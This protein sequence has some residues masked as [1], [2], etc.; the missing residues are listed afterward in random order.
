MAKRTPKNIIAACSLLIL[1]AFVVAPV[2]ADPTGYVPGRFIVKL[3]AGTRFSVASQSLGGNARINPLYPAPMRTSL[4]SVTDW[5][6]YAIVETLDSAAT[7]S[8][9]R[10]LIGTTNVEYVEQD[11]Y[12]DFYE[13]PTDSLFPHQWWLVNNGQE[14]F[15]IDR[16]EGVNNDQLILKT[17]A[18]ETDASVRGFYENP[19]A[20]TTRVIV[21]VIDTGTD[22]F[23]PELAGR[24]W[25]NPDEIPANGIDDDHNGFVDDTIGYDISGD[26]PEF[27]NIQGDNDV[28]DYH[29]HGTHIAGIIAANADGK[30]VVGLA[31]WAE[32][33]TVKVRPNGFL[34]IGTAGVLYAVNNGA[35]V[36]NI[37]WGTP[38]QAVIL[39]DALRFARQNEVFVA[40]AAGNNGDNRRDP[41]AALDSVFAVAAGTSDGYLTNFSSWGPFVDVVAPGEDIL[42]LRASGTDMYGEGGEP[43]VHII[44]PD[45]LYYLS[46]G[47]SMASPI[48]AGSAALIWSFRPDLSRAELETLLRLGADDMTDPRGIGDTLVGP[49]TLSGYGYLNVYRSFQMAGSG[50]LALLEPLQQQRYTGA[51]PIKAAA[52]AG[53]SGQ[54]D[55]EYSVGFMSEDWQSLA[56]GA[57]VPLNS[58]LHVFDLPDLNGWVNLRLTDA[59]GRHSFSRFIYVNSSELTLARPAPDDTLRY[60]VS[61]SGSAFGLDYDSL[62]VSY[63]N[64]TGVLFRLFTSTREFFD[65]TITVWNASGVP[66]GRYTFYLAGYFQSNQTVDSASVF[67]ASAFAAGWPRTL[68]SKGPLSVVAADLDHDGFKEVIA[69]S[70]YG[71]FV[72]RHDGS[73]LTGFPAAPEKD[74]RCMPAIYNV[75]GDPED[76]IIATGADGLYVFNIDGTMVPGWPQKRDMGYS[77]AF[78]YPTPTVATLQEGGPSVIMLI[79]GY[80][81]ILAYRLNGESHFYSLGGHFSRFN[82]A[83]IPIY[84]YAANSVSVADLNGDGLKEVIAGYSGWY[85]KSGVAV[86]DGRTGRPAFG[87][88]APHVVDGQLLF[89]FILADL[90]GDQLPEIIATAQ[91]SVYGRTIFVKTRK[92]DGSGMQDSPGWPKRFP[93]LTGWI[94][95]YPMVADLDLDSIPEVLCTFYEFD[96]A[97]LYIY[98]ADGTPYVSNGGRPEGEAFNAPVT[99]GNPIVADLTGDQHPEI[100]IRSGYIL[101]ATGPERIYI[102]DHTGVL[103]PGYPITTPANPRLVISSTFSPM[104][105]D[106]DNDSL[107][108]LALHGDNGD[109]YIW[110]FDASSRNGNNVGRVFI[111]N[112]NSNI[113]RPR[114]VVTDVPADPETL[115]VTWSLG[116]NYPNPFNPITTISFE[117]P[118]RSQMRIELFNILGQRVATLVDAELGAGNHTIQFDGSEYASGIYLYRMQAGDF[119]ETRKMVLLK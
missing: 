89:G 113:Y 33:M 41:P 118:M 80:G 86:F 21:G 63:R 98:R 42:S 39:E 78:G 119:T 94:G 115:P 96:V 81:E 68:P 112:Q 110:N 37:S 12:L 106:I 97:S 70:S 45:S 13:Y 25:R 102:L 51:V 117:L 5:S 49:D 58:L 82:P 27:F 19:P 103:L 2:S 11:Q 111:D 99:F 77:T 38:F 32:I 66:S 22:I 17:G 88:A 73:V 20:E 14:Y 56:S 36:L 30:G 9:V 60:S 55:L 52:F 65:T 18:P 59:A 8:D 31:P 69:G 101:P 16:I 64:A 76:E 62:V 43:G 84:Y 67:V 44:G 85:P 109:I 71:L 23:H 40:V 15:G 74:M 1:L 72:Y 24:L 28:T 83:E 95:N 79:D 105:D 7:V 54:W 57:S 90:N 3:S 10:D 6:R 116:Q 48:V 50:G 104:V 108:E 29:G 4:S 75:D 46:D 26:I 91:D 34:S 92:P 53:Y 107:V 93:A 87:A 100:V 35:K 47:T 61:I 114:D